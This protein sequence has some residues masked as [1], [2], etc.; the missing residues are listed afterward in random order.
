MLYRTW[1]EDIWVIWD[2]TEP[3]CFTLEFHFKSNPY[4]S[5]EVLTK[6]YTYPPPPA[7]SGVPNADGITSTML[8]FNWEQHVAPQA[9]KVQW[10]DDSK[11]LTKLYGRVAGE[12]GD[13][14]P[15]DPGSFFNFLSMLTILSISAWR[16]PPIFSQSPPAPARTPRFHAR[17]AML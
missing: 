9:T 12:E 14:M 17:H 3:R 7:E 1:R 13:D 10:K 4:F 5:D 11:E 16:S 6:E 15:S 2:K 8:E